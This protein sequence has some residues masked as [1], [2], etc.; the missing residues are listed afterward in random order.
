MLGGRPAGF[1]ARQ[2]L[3]P[4]NYRAL[5]AMARVSTQPLHFAHAYFLGAGTYPT[6]CPVRTPVGVV[7]PTVYSHHD[8]ITV[9]EVFCRGDYRLAPKARVVVDIGSN[10]GISALYFLTRSPQVRVECFEP[11]PRNA[12]RLR[13]NLAAYEG[14]F[15]LR[16]EAVGDRDGLVRFGREDTGRYGAIG[17]ASEDQLEVRCRHV[18]DVLGEVLEREGRIDLLK[19]DTEGLERQ[20]V[21]AI[22]RAILAQLG[23][24]CFETRA[25]LNPW[26][27]RFAMSFAAET[28]RL[29]VRP[30][31]ATAA[32][33]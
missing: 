20:T 13:S 1:V 10:I 12:A 5:G 16:E 27:E 21:E 33:G 26:P 24:I 4:S 3:E 32:A 18:N 22:D 17:R 11:D 31:A 9:N 6:S 29:W 14:R 23:V 28:C 2:L 30:E 7:A 8:V 25:P 15:S 19:I